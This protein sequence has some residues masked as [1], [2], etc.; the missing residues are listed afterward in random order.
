MDIKRTGLLF[1]NNSVSKKYYSVVFLKVQNVFEETITTRFSCM[2]R[3]NFMLCFE[4]SAI[5]RCV[6]QQVVLDAFTNKC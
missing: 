1:V 3:V 4:I 6:L 5:K 2:L